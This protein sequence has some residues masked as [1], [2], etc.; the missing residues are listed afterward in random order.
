MCQNGGVDNTEGGSGWF[1][2]LGGVVGELLQGWGLL[3][4]LRRKGGFGGARSTPATP[5]TYSR[6]SSPSHEHIELTQLGLQVS[7]LKF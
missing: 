5:P 2:A 4:I 7:V 1:G 3:G 6:S